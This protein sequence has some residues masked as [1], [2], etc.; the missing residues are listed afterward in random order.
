MPEDWEYGYDD[1]EIDSSVTLKDLIFDPSNSGIT[2]PRAQELM[3]DW[4]T[5]PEN[6]SGRDA[7]YEALSDYL[8]REYGIDLD[9]EWDWE[10]FREWYD[11]Q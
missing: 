11:S 7:A 1:W 5:S 6:S 9:D 2:D 4:V 8:S 10:D 3:F